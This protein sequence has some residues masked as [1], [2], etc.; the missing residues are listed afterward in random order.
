M[1]LPLSSLFLLL[2]AGSIAAQAR[3][4]LLLERGESLPQPVG[5]IEANNRAVTAVALGND[6]RIWATTSGVRECMY[7][8][9]PRTG[10]FRLLKTGFDPALNIGVGYAYG[11]AVT[12]DGSVVWGY[13]KDVTGLT[14][15]S[16]PMWVGHMQQFWDRK[17]SGDSGL[18]GVRDRA[19]EGQGVYTLAA[20]PGSDGVVGLTWP[21]GHFF[22]QTG[23]RDLTDHGPI[24]GYRTYETPRYAEKIN[25]GTDRNL[26]YARQVSRAIAID[27][28]SGAYTAGAD[29]FLYRYDPAAR[30]LTKLA[31]RL[32]AAA[33]RESFASLD[34]AYVLPAAGN[35]KFTSIVGGTSDGYLFELRILGEGKY[36]L[37]SWGKPF[38]EPGI[39][40]LVAREEF[41]DTGHSTVTI[42]GL[43]GWEG[44]IT[45]AFRAVRGPDRFELIPGSPPVVD[46]TASMEPFS[47]L[48]MDADG[49]VYGGER[50]R[51]GRLVKFSAAA[52]PKKPAAKRAPPPAANE[53]AAKAAL[54]A[55]TPLPCRIVF[56]PDGTTTEASGYTALEVGADGQVYVGS[57]RYGDYGYLLR[58]P[59]TSLLGKAGQPAELPTFME[60]A[61][62]LRDLTGEHRD[63]LNTQGKIHAKI[64]A[65]KDGR[66]WFA[67]KQAH[68][69]F[70]TRPEYEDALGYPGGHL[71]FYDP[72]TKQARTLGILKPREGL[73]GGALDEER[74]KLYFRSEPKN[75]FL[76]YDIKTGV[77]RDLGNLGSSCRYM[78]IDKRGCVYTFGRGQTLCRYHP[79]TQLVEE[80][81]IRV[82]GGGEYVE[83]YVVLLGPDG[84]LYGLRGGHPT[85][86][87]FEIDGLDP[88]PQKD[89]LG[90]RNEVVMWNIASA[91]P[92]G[93]P[94]LDIH[95][96][97]FG[98][99]GKLYWPLV[100]AE[101][102]QAAKRD[103]RVLT[104]MRFDPATG[105]SE[106]VGKPDI[107]GLDEDK[108]RHTYIREDK[109]I[110]DHM[111]GAAVGPD[112]TLYLMDIYPQLNVACF[113]GLT[114]KSL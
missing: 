82:E 85:I 9:D 46:G 61:V 38:A 89:V 59:G 73:M 114:A 22:F 51:I 92:A 102:A 21:D 50:D 2:A 76:A 91:T 53:A 36:E 28:A 45:R 75:H 93:L 90:R 14:T 70:G 58:F 49:N 34:A 79:E 42:D 32:P 10:D 25:Q 62:Y 37:S 39:W 1:R 23:Q 57:A 54:T 112:G 84:K 41:D 64:L 4:P 60:K 105:R 106:L 104:I 72:A 99:D 68:E 101:P 3:P 74:G 110:L 5:A 96:A 47:N 26:A 94:A 77:T 13:Q 33:G 111:Q 66:I 80:W 43:A 16:D 56:A 8:V 71:C 97:V 95:A 18:N 31:E 19:P 86:M 98:A 100:T 35:R 15:K 20:L 109:Y 78:P 29:G 6:G 7:S 108:V 63:G 52:L 103:A 65:A 69:V 83:P 17:D 24:A 107:Q 87:R 67:T 44:G 11:L 88:G 40:G 81:P 12:R 113:Q 30:K 27:P 55:A 48:V